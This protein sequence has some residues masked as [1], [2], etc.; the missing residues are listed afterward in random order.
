MSF[1]SLQTWY[2]LITLELILISMGT[3]QIALTVDFTK[4]GSVIRTIFTLCAVRSLLN[5]LEGERSQSY[6][7]RIVL[8]NC[9]SD[10]HVLYISLD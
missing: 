8:E 10:Y 4:H 1:E 2:S 7:Y 6:L 9:E 3:I 5:M